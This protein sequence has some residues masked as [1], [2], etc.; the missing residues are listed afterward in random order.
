MAANPAEEW[1][2]VSL[3]A[4]LRGGG[5]GGGASD[6]TVDGTADGTVDG[7]DGGVLDDATGSTIV[8]TAD[9]MA[10]GAADRTVD[11]VAIVHSIHSGSTVEARLTVMVTAWRTLQ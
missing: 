10:G 8:G 7:R 6:C 11:R 2:T 5:Q 9:G 1:A 3:V 4:R